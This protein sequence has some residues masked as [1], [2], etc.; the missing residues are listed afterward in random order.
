MSNDDLS[1]PDG[2]A[3]CSLLLPAGHVRTRAGDSRAY[4][5]V[6][7]PAADPPGPVPAADPPGSVPARPAW[8]P[9]LVYVFG[10]VTGASVG[11]GTTLLLW[12]TRP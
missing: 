12:V 6:A 9:W 1:I 7:V 8:S 10:C 4:A 2:P 11:V 5:R 3:P